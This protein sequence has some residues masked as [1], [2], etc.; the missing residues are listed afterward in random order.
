[1]IHFERQIRTDLYLFVIRK[2]FQINWHNNVKLSLAAYFKNLSKF[3]SHYIG[4]SKTIVLIHILK[5]AISGFSNFF[6]R[7]FAVILISTNLTFRHGIKNIRNTF[8]LTTFYDPSITTVELRWFE[9][10]KDWWKQFE[11]EGC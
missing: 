1:M 7:L 10:A 9:R 2:P 5:V 4:F 11:L 3:C 6:F 8:S